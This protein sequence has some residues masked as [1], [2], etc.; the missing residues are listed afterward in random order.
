MKYLLFCILLFAQASHGGE[1]FFFVIQKDGV[2]EISIKEDRLLMEVPIK[3]V[4]PPRATSIAAFYQGYD[5]GRTYKIQVNLAQHP[6]KGWIPSFK[7]NNK[8]FLHGVTVSRHS[9]LKFSSAFSIESDSIE[10][11]LQWTKALSQ[12]LKIP[13]QKV[14]VDLEK[15]EDVGD[16]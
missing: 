13:E 4:S 14:D 12:L 15:P 9:E 2:E 16:K 3:K 11:V 8:V 7:L 10:E 6:E 1:S 5:N